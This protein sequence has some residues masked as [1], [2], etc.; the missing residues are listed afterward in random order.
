MVLVIFATLACTNR[1][2]DASESS[3][4]SRLRWPTLP[5][6]TAV[7]IFV[8][9]TTMMSVGLFLTWDAYCP[10]S[11]SQSCFPIASSLQWYDLA[12]HNITLPF[13]DSIGVILLNVACLLT[14]KTLYGFL[15]ALLC[16]QWSS[17]IWVFNLGSSKVSNWT[18]ATS[19]LLSSTIRTLVHSTSYS[20]FVVFSTTRSW[21]LTGASRPLR[22]WWMSNCRLAFSD[23]S[24][25][26]CHNNRFSSYKYILTDSP[27]KMACFW[28]CSNV[29]NSSG[30]NFFINL[31]FAASKS[32]F[33]SSVTS[34]HAVTASPSSKV[35]N[36][37][38][39]FLPSQLFSSVQISNFRNH[40]LTSPPERGFGILTCVASMTRNQLCYWC[41]ISDQ[42]VNNN[43]H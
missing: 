17:W 16:G 6:I 28:N 2:T 18:A 32:F 24:G 26:A 38:V 10:S 35:G 19:L 42:S 7:C 8:V 12:C 15:Y 40:S 22:N 14:I 43:T 23:N 33:S 34:V 9:A 11:A 37:F 30:D 3:I 21:W 29:T 36:L 13:S 20:R 5:I 1:D 41:N 25:I 27:G 39:F 4:T 31:A